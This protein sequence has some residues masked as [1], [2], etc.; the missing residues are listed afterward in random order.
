MALIQ[1][2]AS[3]VR[4]AVKGLV[5]VGAVIAVLVVLGRLYTSSASFPTLTLVS[6]G[7]YDSGP[8]TRR[9]TSSSYDGDIV[10]HQFHIETNG[11]G[12]AGGG[13]RWFF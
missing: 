2:N 8:R 11:C 9:E 4:W 10:R 7:E 3:G 5:V 1:V 6:G 12:G 13:N